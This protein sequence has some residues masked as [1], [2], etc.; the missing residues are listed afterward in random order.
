[1]NYK[2]HST[3]IFLAGVVLS[4]LAASPARADVTTTVDPGPL[5][6]IGIAGPTEQDILSLFTPVGVG[7]E[8]LGRVEVM[9]ADGKGIRLGPGPGSFFVQVEHKNFGLTPGFV[10]WVSDVT[11]ELFDENGNIFLTGFANDSLIASGGGFSAGISPGAAIDF[12]GYAITF[13]NPQVGPV[14][15]NASVGLFLL[16]DVQIV[17]EPTSLALL[18]LG[19]LIV[20][21]PQRGRATTA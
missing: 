1:M 13:E 20:L 17:P 14:P 2:T 5:G 12:H 9:F 4:L 19:G 6:P 15:S 11:L 21:R 7:G 18:G 3:K 8:T 16:G 10:N